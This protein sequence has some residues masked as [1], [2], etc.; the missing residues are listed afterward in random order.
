MPIYMDLHIV[1][2]ITAIGAA[3]AHRQDLLLQGQY[4]CNCMTYWVDESKNSAFCL[5]DAPS[6][7]AVKRL[8]DQAH[9]L[10]THQIIEVNTNV[11]ES[12]L[13][14][15][16]DPDTPEILEGQLK[17]FND[18]AFRVLV[19]VKTTDPVLLANALGTFLSRK[20]L[21]EYHQRVKSN[22]R[23]YNGDI[24]EH[25][26]NITTILSFTS[27]YKA[28]SCALSLMAGFSEEKQNR[29]GLRISINA[30]M[31]V[32]QSKRLFGDT[33]SLGEH[34]LGIAK[35]GQIKVASII[36]EIAHQDFFSQ[37]RKSISSLST[38]DEKL[39]TNLSLILDEHSP[40]ERFGG[41]DFC[42]LMGLSKS[43]LNRLTQSLA[44]KSPNTLSQEHRLGRAL[45]LLRKKDRTIS[46]VA[47]SVGFTTPS[48][49]AKCFKC[50]FGI[51]PSSYIQYLNQ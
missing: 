42:K 48:Y 29:L 27:A 20:L 11:V 12:F 24:A 43:S 22:S 32:A 18:P 8:H 44:G 6:P 1:P 46:E 9:G 45:S 49:F 51:S 31:P 5:I 19:L 2:G 37:D 30:G 50:H 21:S 3:E 10:I 35:P 34:L 28:V 36:N 26:E 25:A 38:A 17:V 4:N 15:I 41:E 13:G 33:I 39:L 40:N 47:F 7:D 14:R 16:Y 23:Q